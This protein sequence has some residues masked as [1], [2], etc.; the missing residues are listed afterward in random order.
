LTPGFQKSRTRSL[1]AGR[2]FSTHAEFFWRFD[3]W[4]HDS[5]AVVLSFQAAEGRDVFGLSPDGVAWV[6]AQA[7]RKWSTY[8][9]GTL[10]SEPVS[11]TRP[12]EK[13]K[14]GRTPSENAVFGMTLGQEA[15]PKAGFTKG[16]TAQEW[17]AYFRQTARAAP[18]GRPTNPP[19]RSGIVGPDYNR[20]L[21]H[22]WGRP[23]KPKPP[24]EHGR[25]PLSPPR[26]P[27]SL[28]PMGRSV[29]TAVK[30][31][32]RAAEPTVVRTTL[33][34]SEQI[35][36]AADSVPQGLLYGG[37]A[38]IDDVWLYHQRDPANP[39][40]TLDEFKSIIGDERGSLQLARADMVAA[41]SEQKLRDSDVVLKSGK[42]TLAT[43]NFVRPSKRSEPK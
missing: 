20:L 17:A 35:Q 33:A 43:W 28:S 38:W 21:Q 31:A 19:V 16:R 36:Q 23:A 3:A 1:L 15:G 41:F 27:T 13:I 5:W 6:K 10:K 22:I 34:L 26:S 9:A 2:A 8:K 29:A 40:L 25:S 24:R 12:A 30:Q 7:D 42:A 11:T 18:P 32:V 39:R 4:T 37:K 14:G